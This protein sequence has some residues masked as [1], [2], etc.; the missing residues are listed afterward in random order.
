METN[1]DT[2]TLSL[3]F[4]IKSGVLNHVRF[5]F[6]Q[7]VADLSADT[8]E[9]HEHQVYL[10]EYSSYGLTSHFFYVNMSM[11]Y[12]VW[13]KGKGYFLIIDNRGDKDD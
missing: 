13:V 10:C 5:L 7:A 8:K 9:T 4:K 3:S 1:A 12:G 2:V 6:H 11:E